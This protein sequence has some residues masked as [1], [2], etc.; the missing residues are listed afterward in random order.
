MHTVLT[1]AALSLHE[2][3][4]SRLPVVF[5]VAALLAAGTGWFAGALALT[6]TAAMRVALAAPVLRFAAV[7]IVAGFA[8]ASMA[9]EAEER[10]RELL[11]ALPIARSQYVLGRLAGYGALAWII[12]ALCTLVLLLFATPAQAVA[13]GLSLAGE[14]SIVAAF[15][16]FAA[17]GLPPVL[18]PL[19]ATLGFYLLARMAAGMQALG[20]DG[21]A[22]ALGATATDAIAM[23]LPRLDAFARTEWLIYDSASAT[24][25]AYALAQAAIYVALLGSACAFDLQRRDVG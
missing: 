11:L 19:A 25:V 1:I 17:A 3:W 6:E 5:L 20:N 14:L 7:F 16:L 13:W 22:G 4:R 15:A 8:T 2:A 18:A 21:S 9:R 12:G 10:M 24:D 23:L